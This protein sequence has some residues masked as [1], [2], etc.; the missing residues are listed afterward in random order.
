MTSGSL[1][2]PQMHGLLAMRLQFHT[3]GALV[4]SLGDAAFCKI[5]VVEPRKKAY[6]DFYKKL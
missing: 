4:V 2:K 1:M 5:A 6:A 3:V